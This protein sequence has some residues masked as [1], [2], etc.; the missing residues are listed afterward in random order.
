MTAMNTKDKKKDPHTTLA[1]FLSF[2]ID[3]T[4]PQT[5][6]V[7]QIATRNGTMPKRR[8]SSFIKL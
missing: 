7:A 8:S 5:K 3:F 6:V 2:L 1:S 4:I